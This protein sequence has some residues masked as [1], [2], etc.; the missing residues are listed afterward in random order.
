MIIKRKFARDFGAFT[1]TLIIVS[2]VFNLRD[3]PMMSVY[4]ED[5][6]F[7]YLVAVFCFLVPFGLICA[8]FSSHFAKAGGIYTWVEGSLGSNFGFQL[9][10]LLWLLQVL[11]LLTHYWQTIA[12]LFFL[13][14]LLCCG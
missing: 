7:L 13:A 2:A 12:F 8:E 3:L 11:F 4:G 1:L 6:I 9:S 10:C 14:C 5:A